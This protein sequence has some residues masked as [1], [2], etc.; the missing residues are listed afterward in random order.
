M[1]EMPRPRLA[2]V[3]SAATPVLIADAPV[4]MPMTMLLLPVTPST[5]ITD[6]GGG[7]TP[8]K[9]VS[10]FFFLAVKSTEFHLIPNENKQNSTDSKKS[11][12]KVMMKN[13]IV[14]TYHFGV[15]S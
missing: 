5:C 10:F 8:T 2:G 9:I 12:L 3:L 1:K 6:G 11:Y 14:T 13:A 7:E 4:A 15:F